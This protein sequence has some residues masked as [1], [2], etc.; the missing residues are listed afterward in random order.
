MVIC[1]DVERDDHDHDG[2]ERAAAIKH[3][4]LP[5]R[6]LSRRFRVFRQTGENIFTVQPSLLD[7]RIGQ[8]SFQSGLKL[9]GR[10]CQTSMDQA[11][12]RATT[13][14]P[15]MPFIGVGMSSPL[16]ST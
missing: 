4:A 12:S 15:R 1:G 14:M 5:S 11:H 16:S 13:K 2:Q 6:H 3:K 8:C 10:M 9:I 7:C